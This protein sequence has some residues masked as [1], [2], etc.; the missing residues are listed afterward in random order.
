MRYRK[1]TEEKIISLFA[2]VCRVMEGEGTREE[3]RPEPV[4]QVSAWWTGWS[5]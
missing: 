3:V 1:S 5:E 2:G 4:L